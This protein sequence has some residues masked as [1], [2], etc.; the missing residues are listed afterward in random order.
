MKSEVTAGS[1]VPAWMTGPADPLCAAP[2]AHERAGGTEGAAGAGCAEPLP[3]PAPDVCLGGP[4][5]H[6]V[7]RVARLHRMAAARVL[8]GLGLYPGQEFLM[9]HL[10]DAGPVRQS[11]LI[12]A[13]ELDPSTV[14][15]ML[16][17][18]EHAGHV[19]RTP[20]PADRRAVLVEA[21]A[22]SCALR[23]AVERAWSQLEEQTLTGLAEDERTELIRLLGKVEGN[24]CHHAAECPGE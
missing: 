12:R 5:G 6:A 21:T 7:S 2:P 3:L 16:Q 23:S 17:R 22:E 8:R 24:L 10:W 18:L 19:R 11:E 15:K 14:T 13:V 20:D 1:V 4:A 9:M